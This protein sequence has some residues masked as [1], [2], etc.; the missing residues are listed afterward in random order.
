MTFSPCTASW[1][2]AEVISW[3]SCNHHGS[4]IAVASLRLQRISKSPRS[5]ILK[6]DGHKPEELS[7]LRTQTETWHLQ[8]TLTT[9]STSVRSGLLLPRLLCSEQCGAPAA[10]QLRSSQ[11]SCCVSLLKRAAA[12]SPRGPQ[13]CLHQSWYRSHTLPRACKNISPMSAAC[14]M[15]V[16][17]QV[18]CWIFKLSASIASIF[19]NL[20]QNN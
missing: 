18:I 4:L 7:L 5:A 3:V 20:T 10:H 9:E 14:S 8:G 19:K 13:T 12:R 17:H 15:I 16:C 11:E 1:C 2:V 6:Q